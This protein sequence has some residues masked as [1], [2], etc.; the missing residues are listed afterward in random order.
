M[1]WEQTVKHPVE[2][3]R[4]KSIKFIQINHVGC[5]C[6]KH[7]FS[8]FPAQPCTSDLP[9]PWALCLIFAPRPVKLEQPAARPSWLRE[10]WA[11]RWANKGYCWIMLYLTEALCAERAERAEFSHPARLLGVYMTPLVLHQGWKHYINNFAEIGDQVAANQTQYSR[12]GRL[13]DAFWEEPFKKIL[14]EHGKSRKFT[15]HPGIWVRKYF[16][17]WQFPYCWSSNA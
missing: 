7:G 13:S 10:R 3:T 1:A 12:I 5:G 4:N 6:W 2:N 16:W 8:P 9:R 17:A 15:V 14:R 11:K